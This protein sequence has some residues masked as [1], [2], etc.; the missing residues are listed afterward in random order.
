[1][2]GTQG[3]P[4]SLRSSRQSAAEEGASTHQQ[5]SRDCREFTLLHHLPQL[6][7]GKYLSVYMHVSKLPEAEEIITQQKQKEY[8]EFTWVWEQLIFPLATV[9][10]FHK[11]W[12][13][14]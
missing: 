2:A 3:K 8:M 5:C 1:M 13:I 10:E 11:S 14:G 7:T 9:G 12:D 6:V 4:A